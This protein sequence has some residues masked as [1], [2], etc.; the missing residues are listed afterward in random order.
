MNLERGVIPTPDDLKTLLASDAEIYTFSGADHQSEIRIKLDEEFENT[1][2][3][4]NRLVEDIEGEA[5]LTHRLTL[6]YITDFF[7]DGSD[8]LYYVKGAANMSKFLLGTFGGKPYDRPCFASP[9]V[10]YDADEI[11]TSM[12]LDMFASDRVSKTDTKGIRWK[13]LYASGIKAWEK[14]RF[15]EEKLE[16]IR[17]R[18]EEF[19]K[20]EALRKRQAERELSDSETLFTS[21]TGDD[22]EIA[23]SEPETPSTEGTTPGSNQ[24]DQSDDA[25]EDLGEYERFE[26]SD[27]SMDTPDEAEGSEEGEILL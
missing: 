25:G 26:D 17:K 2:L 9:M 16:A 10:V 20:E 24:D 23:A 15:S 12:G 11:F 14:L 18:N 3:V 5:D 4:N 6:V 1:P 13:Y 19:D 27:V 7:K 22:G 21:D 8:F